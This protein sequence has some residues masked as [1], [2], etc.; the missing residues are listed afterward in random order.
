MI[1]ECAADLLARAQSVPELTSR[2]GLSLGGHS[3]D[4]TLLKIPL[5]AAWVIYGGD[6]PDE[7]PFGSS[8]QGGGG[9]VPQQQVMLSLWRVVVYLPYTT[10]EDLIN[11]QYP[12]IESV[13]MAVRNTITSDDNGTAAPSGH[14]WRY[15]GQKLVLVY[16]DRLA[17]EQ[18]YTLD[19]V[20]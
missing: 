20:L 6:Q 17:Y 19:M 15:A 7:A 18:H 1:A 3:I 5:P 9:M 14:R 8:G 12:L 16:N 4:P 11:V 13:L 10:D 2:C